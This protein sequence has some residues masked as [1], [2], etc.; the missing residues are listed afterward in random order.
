VGR[1][2]VA[3]RQRLFHTAVRTRGMERLVGLLERRRRAAILQHSVRGG[4]VRPEVLLVQ[5][6][7][8]DADDV[9][10]A[11]RLLTAYRT[12]QADGHV[13]A[14]RGAG[15]VDLWTAIEQRKHG[16]ATVLERGSAR[17]LAAILCNVARHPAGE[18]ILQ[19]DAEHERIVRDPSYR[20]FLALLAQD[21]LVSLAE[22]V[23]ALPVENPAQGMFG[24]SLHRDTG[25]LVAAV[26]ARLGLD[27]T[28]PDLDGGLLKL[29]TPRGMFGERD[30]NAIFTAHLLTRIL[31]DTEQPC[32]CEIGAGS[33]RTAYWSHRFGVRALSL[34]DLPDV[35][36]VQGY[37]LLK[38]LPCDRVTLYGEPVPSEPEGVRILP[39][40]ALAS[41]DARH[42]DL[43]LNQDSFPEMAP[44]TVRDYLAWVRASAKRLLSINHESKPPYGRDLAHASV[45]EEIARVGGFALEDRFPYWLRRGY[46][47]E[48]Y[49][50]VG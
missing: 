13:G 19:G 21:T 31:R 11:A 18:G 15:R 29:R 17:E 34:V 10:I 42:F 26:E 8:P 9:S 25:A 3:A 45:P 2:G 41:A 46:V 39:A 27:L 35:N 43:V 1:L 33:G 47:A 44:A 7:V 20:A 49:S 30:L 38:A 48:L 24:T 32:V 4:H 14:A 23:G 36:V 16:F 12:A 5:N 40:G 37:Y 22:A 6:R 28:P 50:V